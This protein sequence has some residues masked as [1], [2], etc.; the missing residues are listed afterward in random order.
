MLF[1]SADVML[2][3]KVL[4]FYCGSESLRLEDGLPR[5]EL[6]DAPANLVGIIRGTQPESAELRLKVLEL[7]RV[8]TQVPYS[9]QTIW[10]NRRRVLIR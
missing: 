6:G 9:P 1:V 3:K 2:S 5:A 8:A 7:S 10:G 4:A